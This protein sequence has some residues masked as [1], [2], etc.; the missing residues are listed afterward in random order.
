M[1]L[2]KSVIFV[3]SYKG[4]KLQKKSEEIASSL[5]NNLEKGNGKIEIAKIRREDLLQL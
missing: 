2:Q 3:Q 4:G 5:Q 1:I